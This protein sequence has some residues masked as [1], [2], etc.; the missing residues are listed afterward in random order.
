MLRTWQE[1]LISVKAW[2]ILS[3]VL[4]LVAFGPVSAQPMPM[5]GLPLVDQSGRAVQGDAVTLLNFVFTNC[6]STCPTQTHELVLL[7]E[8][9]TADVRAKVRFISISVDPASDTP[10]LLRAYAKRMGAD[11]PA[12]QFVT[13]SPMV[14]GQLLER[15]QALGPAAN[16]RGVEQHTTSLYLFGADGNLV[17]RYR[18]VPID[19]QRL[20]DEISHLTRLQQKGHP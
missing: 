4:G 8:G 6:S 16:R 15:M 3:M 1:T 18:G 17:Q 9:L 13:G 11:L 14:V 19:R 20:T 5:R 10:A 7:H 12:W 2:T